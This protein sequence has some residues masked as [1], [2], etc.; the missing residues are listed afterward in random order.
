[1]DFQ[2]LAAQRYSCRDMDPLHKVE[3]EKIDRIIQAAQ[4]APTACNLQRWRIKVVQSAEAIRKVRP[5]T[6]CHFN[7]PLIFVLSVILDGGEKI[8]NIEAAYRFAMIDAGIVISQM[9][10]Q[11]QDLGL[12]TTIV[13]MFD[14]MRLQEVLLLPEGQTP[15]LLLPTGYPG[16][17]GGPCILH[18]QRKKQSETVEWI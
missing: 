4:T 16:K 15:I 18:K 17:R 14:T 10:L 8:S 11:A 13:G 12:G 1:M 7:A 2:T 9:A 5:L 6:P 3:R